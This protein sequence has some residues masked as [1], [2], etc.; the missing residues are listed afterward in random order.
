[1]KEMNQFNESKIK[2]A[3][4][5]IALCGEAGSG[6]TAIAISPASD[7]AYSVLSHAL[8]SDG[9]W[10]T[11]ANR[12]YLYTTEYEDHIQVKVKLK[13]K[14][15]VAQ[16][17]KD[18]VLAVVRKA[19]LYTAEYTLSSDFFTYFRS[20]LRDGRFD[21]AL[22]A[23]FAA[24]DMDK[25]C[26]KI[27]ITCGNDVNKIFHECTTDPVSLESIVDIVSSYLDSD[28]TCSAM[29]G[30]VYERFRHTF[31]PGDEVE[32]SIDLDYP[33]EWKVRV[34][35]GPNDKCLRSLE[36]I[37]DMVTVCSP[38]R[39]VL[40]TFVSD[41]KAYRCGEAFMFGILDTKGFDST[42]T[43]DTVVERLAWLHDKCRAM[44]F[45]APMAVSNRRVA[46]S[47]Y[48]A[49][50]GNNA[51]KWSGS[52]KDYCAPVY[53]L[54]SKMDACVGD[55][56][57]TMSM[58]RPACTEDYAI[59]RRFDK[60]NQETWYGRLVFEYRSYLCYSDRCGRTDMLTKESRKYAAQNV[61]KIMLEDAVQ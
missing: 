24:E 37:F 29:V 50:S 44:V 54:F 27:Y 4:P 1:M 15:S 40:K 31:G 39:R 47:I 41:N 34:V 56:T 35:F 12:L 13:D 36:P 8:A 33:D 21:V 9:Y 38:M 52:S 30:T 51:L 16:S 42:T 5:V 46:A 7:K 18:A 11:Q 6:K 48:S 53:F 57:S 20:Y 55:L 2:P 14:D 3:C 25:L 28:G 60:A 61:L 45:V 43:E 49:L 23:M 26:D 17:L 32:A 58:L 59:L 19:A 10:G 22:L